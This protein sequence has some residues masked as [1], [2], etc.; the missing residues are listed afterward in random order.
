VVEVR[1]EAGLKAKERL[2]GLLRAGSTVR[3]AIAALSPADL[4]AVSM[5]GRSSSVKGPPS[6][7]GWAEAR[8]TRLW[9]WCG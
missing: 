7:A 9:H 6:L 5:S 2:A 3:T 4:S 8:Q 1:D